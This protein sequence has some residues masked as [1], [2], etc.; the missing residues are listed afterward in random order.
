MPQR[1]WIALNRVLAGPPDPATGARVQA[2]PSY[3]YGKVQ[4]DGQVDIINQNGILFQGSSQINVTT[5]VASS[6][7]IGQAWMNLSQ[8]NDY[9]QSG[10]A[11]QT[12]YSFQYLVAPDGNGLFAEQ[13]RGALGVSVPFV[14]AG[15]AVEGAVRLAPGAQITTPEISSSDT[16]QGR[17]VLAAPNVSNAGNISTPDGQTLL[18]GARNFTLFSNDLDVLDQVT[19]SPRDS[20]STPDQTPLDAEPGLRGVVTRFGANDIWGAQAPLIPGTT[21]TA[22]GKTVI[23]T[24]ECSRVGKAAAGSGGHA[25]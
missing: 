1:N 6:L 19:L 16:T 13:F 5:L 23:P 21:H 25:A 20:N 11:G 3:I 15:D 8:R 22:S 17:V 18:I 9:F 7:D 4:A 10:P 24:S 14:F 2:A 12:S